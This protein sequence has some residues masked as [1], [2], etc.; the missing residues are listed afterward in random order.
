MRHAMPVRFDRAERAAAVAQALGTVTAD[1][2]GYHV[3]WN[4]EHLNRHLDSL[5]RPHGPAAYPRS[6]DI[7]RRSILLS[8]GVVDAGLGAGFGINIQSSDEEIE[9]VARQFHAAAE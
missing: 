8:V 1:C 7:L 6:F 9:Q 4:I 3:Q 2:T 5:G